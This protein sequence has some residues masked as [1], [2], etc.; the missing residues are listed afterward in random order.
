MSDPVEVLEPDDRD[1]AGEKAPKP[2]DNPFV[3]MIRNPAARTYLL[4]SA[5]GLAVLATGLGLFYNSPVGAIV[6]AGLGLGGLAFRWPAG[7]PGVAFAVAYFSLMPMGVPIDLPRVNQIPD[8]YANQLSLLTD[9]LVVAAGLVHLIA[10]YRYH[11]VIRAGM[12]FDAPAPFVKPGAKPTVRP[13]VPVRDAELWFLFARVG[14]FVLAGQL[15]W[16]LVTKLKVDFTQDFP[17]RFHTD[18]LAEMG[19]RLGSGQIPN[20]LSRFLLT[21]GAL[22][23]VGFVLWF[24]L[25]YWRLAVLNRDEARASCLDQEW[26]ANRREYNR[27]EKW[28]GWM[29]QRLAGTLPRKGCGAW[30]LVVGVPLMLFTLFAICLACMGAFR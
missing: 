18:Y 8:R 20:G 12:P 7:P 17:V 15:L 25:W 3:Q 11:A 24:G 4:V 21:V 1:E 9:L 22:T 28:R 26:A 27:P 2:S 19:D 10:A 16:L 29:K 23:G 14:V 13:A 30:F 6:V 5:G